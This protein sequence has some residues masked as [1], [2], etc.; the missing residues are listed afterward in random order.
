MRS[1]LPRFFFPLAVDGNRKHRETAFHVAGSLIFFARAT[2][3]LTSEPILV[4]KLEWNSFSEIR[5]RLIGLSAPS[6]YVSLD[7]IHSTIISGTLK[8]FSEKRNCREGGYIRVRIAIRNRWSQTLMIIEALATFDAWNSAVI[9]TAETIRGSV[10]INEC[11]AK[12]SAP[13]EK[14]LR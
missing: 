5:N 14:R 2:S 7:D 8:Y 3:S 11:S 10:L 4:T 1:L 13:I 9:I 12:W 6:P